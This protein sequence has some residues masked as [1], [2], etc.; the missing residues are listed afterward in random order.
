M[1]TRGA[2]PEASREPITTTHYTKLNRFE[3]H[4]A[5]SRLGVRYT[6]PNPTQMWV[7]VGLLLCF[8]GTGLTVPFWLPEQAPLALFAAAGFAVVALVPLAHVYNTRTNPRAVFDRRRGVALLGTG[9]KVRGWSG[10]AGYSCSARL[11]PRVQIGST[12]GRR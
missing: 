10:C 1:G 5:G 8:F 6:H 9:R 12:E 2:P 3:L 4:P 7:M 11:D